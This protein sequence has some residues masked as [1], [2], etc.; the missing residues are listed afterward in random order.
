VGGRAASVGMHGSIK[1]RGRLLVEEGRHSMG[2]IWTRM[3]WLATGWPT[4]GARGA[5][6]RGRMLEPAVPVCADRSRRSG[7]ARLGRCEG[8][9]G[10]PTVAQVAG[11]CAA[12]GRKHLQQSPLPPILAIV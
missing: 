10:A 11:H 3:G 5:G 8:K 4:H 12:F 2:P 9:R 1:P 7:G 6:H